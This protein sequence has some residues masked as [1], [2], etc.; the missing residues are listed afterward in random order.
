MSVRMHVLAMNVRGFSKYSLNNLLFLATWKQTAR[1]QTCRERTCRPRTHLISA[2][3][4]AAQVCHFPVSRVAHQTLGGWH[5]GITD[6]LRTTYDL[7]FSAAPVL[8]ARQSD[9]NALLIGLC[10]TTSVAPLSACR[11]SS[12][13]NW[14]GKSPLT[15]KTEERLRA[16]KHCD[17]CQKMDPLTLYKPVYVIRQN[18]AI[19]C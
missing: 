8:E 3:A 10:F 7:H 16:Q 19:P 12:L 14:L 9:T 11:G 13:I 4:S 15:L 17:V 2:V 6:H 5:T 1:R 18:H